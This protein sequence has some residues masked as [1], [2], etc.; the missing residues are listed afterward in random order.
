MASYANP[1]V[2]WLTG[3]SGAGKTTIAHDMI[4]QL[5]M[6]GIAPVLLD[7]DQIRRSLKQLDFSEAARKAHNL[8][9]GQMASALEKRGKVVIVS[10]ISPYADIRAEV[11][12]LCE[13]FVEV[14]V[15]TPLELCICRDPKGLYKK[16]ISGQIQ[17]FTGIT[18]PYYPPANPEV[19]VYTDCMSASDCAEK[20]LR[21]C[22]A[23][24]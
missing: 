4:K 10:L 17:H 18:A 19:T 7:G 23:K 22:F 20:I 3:L 16:A 6:S 8:R 1:A 21:Y 14:Y 13:T 24:D 9:V 2:I 15:Q 12:S 11:R 5:K